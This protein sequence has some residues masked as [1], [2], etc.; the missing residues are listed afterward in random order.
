M[1]ACVR[2]LARMLPNLSAL[3][4][5]GM[6]AADPSKPSPITDLDEDHLAKVLGSVLRI[7]E[8]TD[9]YG[10]TVEDAT[11]YERRAHLV[12]LCQKIATLRSIS[13]TTNA[14]E[15]TV[16]AFLELAS[17]LQIDP[18]ETARRVVGQ[19]ADAHG[20]LRDVYSNFF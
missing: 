3:A 19:E 8:P 12:T 16:G 2:D 5:T 15:A 1:C 13:R 20:V 14:S 10:D 6:Q 7:M 4:P 18:V 11:P 17:I 9:V